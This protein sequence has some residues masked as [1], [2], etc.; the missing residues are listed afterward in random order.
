LGSLDSSG[1][2]RQL[3]GAR[4]HVTGPKFTATVEFEAQ[5][6]QTL[7]SWRMVFETVEE[8]IHTV[9]TYKADEGI[10]QNVEKL[11]VYLTGMNAQ[12]GKYA[13]V[14]GLHL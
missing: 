8:F 5:G 4:E 11:I 7:I 10:K 2:Y 1:T 3:V 12:T 6:E 13:Q 9:K 14:N